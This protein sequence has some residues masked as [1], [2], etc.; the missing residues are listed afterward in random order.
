M[1]NSLVSIIVPIYKA[2]QWLPRCIDSILAQTMPNFE[3]LL[4]NDGSPDRCGKI[5]D[6]YAVKDDRVRVFHKENG[7]VSSAR[8][9]GVKEA[10]GEY[11]IHVDPDD[12]IA[13]NM[14]EDMVEKAQELDCDVLMC[15]YYEKKGDVVIYNK[16]QPKSLSSKEILKE[17]L[18]CDIHGSLCNKLVK[19]RLYEEFDLKFYENIN[20]RED[21]LIWVQ[22]FSNDVKVGYINKAYYYYLGLNPDSIT[23]RYTNKHYEWHNNFIYKLK[24]FL[25]DYKIYDTEIILQEADCYIYGY[26]GNAITLKE[27][28]RKMTIKYMLYYL[29]RNKHQSIRMKLVIFIKRYFYS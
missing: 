29:F 22:L 9:L 19:H 24:D 6:E 7:G 18:V 26:I 25:S 17:M 14:L 27:F 16:Q 13:V 1:K 21:L 10:N 20:C 2:E 11:S 5:C 15:D 4:V 12:Y 3:L 28:K 8:A 23:T